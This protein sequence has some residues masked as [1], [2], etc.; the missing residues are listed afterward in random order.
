MNGQIDLQPLG[1]VK[2]CPAPPWRDFGFALP[3]P[4]PNR[5][6]RKP[7]GPGDRGR[8]VPESLENVVYRLHGNGISEN[9]IIKQAPN[10]PILAGANH[11][12]SNDYAR[13]ESAFDIEAVKRA[14]ADRKVTQTDLA[15]VASLPSQSAMSNILKGKR[16]VTADEAAIIYRFLGIAGPK[17]VPTAHHVPIIGFGSASSWREAIQ[18]PIG[19]MTIPPRKAGPKAFAIEIQGDSL[20]KVVDDGG[21]VVVDPEQK[22]LRPGKLYLIQNGEHETTVKCYE[23]DPPRFVPMSNNPLHKPIPASEVDVIIGRIC[24]QGGPL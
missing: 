17:P 19:G 4:I 8:L 24:W 6:D 21:Y 23:R 3:A 16:K 18:L 20:D 9:R 10:Y 22:E 15:K 11:V 7:G 2:H 14:M 13:M 12:L 1:R 5:L